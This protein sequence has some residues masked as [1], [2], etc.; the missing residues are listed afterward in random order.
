M[1]NN[2]AHTDEQMREQAERAREA[3]E[4]HKETMTQGVDER[5]AVRDQIVADYYE[6][7]A[8]AKPT[9]TQRECDL[10]RTGAMTVDDEKE[11]DGS[12]PEGDHVRR[13]L[14][15]KVPGNNP[16]E[17]RMENG[18]VEGQEGQPVRRGPGRPRKT[19]TPPT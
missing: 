13:I 12:G 9:P 4:R 11:D 5:L 15:A 2:L 17:T 18:T 14:E 1:A 16:Y 6:R 3:A 10:I 19:E 8:A 7:S